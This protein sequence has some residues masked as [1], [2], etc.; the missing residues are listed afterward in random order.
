MS[1][2]RPHVR[3]TLGMASASKFLAA[4]S[5]VVDANYYCLQQQ[6]VLLSGAAGRGT[7]ALV[8]CRART[9]SAG[10]KEPMW[11]MNTMSAT[12]FA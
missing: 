10:T 9:F 4:L 11:A 7:K 2:N 6:R 5:D 8:S 3:L 12:C 1:A